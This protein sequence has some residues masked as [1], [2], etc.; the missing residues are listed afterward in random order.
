MIRRTVIMTSI[1]TMAVA[2]SVTTSHIA[3]GEDIGVPEKLEFGAA[4]EETLGHFRALELNLDAGNGDLARAHATH[5]V[6][7]LYDSMK[8][9][10][11]AADP[12]LD[13]KL[14]TILGE[15]RD[16]ASTE[17]SRSEAQSAIDDAKEAVEEARMAVIGADLS[18]YYGFKLMLMTTLLET[19]IAEYGEAVSDGRIAEMAEFQDGSAFVW[20]SQQVLQTMEPELGSETYGYL[21]LSYGS[22]WDAYDAR[23]DPSE[24]SRLTDSVLGQVEVAVNEQLAERLE[25]GAALEETRGHF[26]ALELNLD[27]GNGDLARA[28]ATHPVAELYDSMKPTLAA[29]DPALDRKL[30]TILGELRDKASTEVSRSEAQSAIDDAKEAVEEAR[31]AVIGADLSAYYGFKLMLMTTLLETSIAEYG[32]AVSDGRIAEMAEFQDGSAFVWQAEQILRTMEGDLDGDDYEEL[33]EVFDEIN[34]AYDDR[35]DPS[36]IDERTSYLLAEI[37]GILGVTGGDEDTLLTYVDNINMLLEEAREEYNA[38]NSD[39]ALSHVTK[40]YLNNYEFLEMPLMEAGERELMERVEVMMRE[41]LRNMIKQGA[42]ASEVSD[43]I[44]AILVE[45][46]TV[47]V[48]VPEFGIMASVVLAA[49]VALVLGL[50]T[51]SRRIAGISILPTRT[52]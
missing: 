36:E 19:S 50:S 33:V 22:L 32:E 1:M 26:R 49:A 4:L 44:D 6:A 17:V 52:A 3:Y 51:R 46:E 27:A 23:L 45:M 10:L 47:A 39:L 15:L 40:A 13:R 14:G 8:P 21:E 31:M 16:K 5:P 41:D 25:F 29:A 20:R 43:Q 38:G 35:L 48:I 11:A 30:G 7:E 42:P 37:N 9:T 18:A 2:L 28:H 24:V 12:A 34:E